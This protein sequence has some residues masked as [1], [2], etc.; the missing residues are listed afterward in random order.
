ME[1]FKDHMLATRLLDFVQGG[2]DG[3][4]EDY[5]GHGHAEGDR[6][7]HGH[8]ADHGHSTNTDNALPD[9]RG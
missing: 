4:P 9:I 7:E 2:N 5:H 1:N 8:S 6:D 3:R